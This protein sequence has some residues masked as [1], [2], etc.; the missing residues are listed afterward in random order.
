MSAYRDSLGRETR[1]RYD[2]AVTRAGELLAAAIADLQADGT[3]LTERA[4]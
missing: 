3:L 1:A 2:Q 4:A